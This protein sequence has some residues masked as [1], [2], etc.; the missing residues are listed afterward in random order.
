[1]TASLAVADLGG[2]L[3]HPFMRHAFLAGTAV[4]VAAAGRLAGRRVL[5]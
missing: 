1:M 5:A 2:M 4:A 3:G